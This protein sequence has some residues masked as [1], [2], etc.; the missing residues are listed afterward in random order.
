MKQ[1]DY[2]LIWIIIRITSH[3]KNINI[4]LNNAFLKTEIVNRKLSEMKINLKKCKSKNILT[5]ID[6]EQLII[7]KRDLYQRQL[8]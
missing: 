3:I 8:S 6:L 5:D 7:E 4:N 1:V 2:I